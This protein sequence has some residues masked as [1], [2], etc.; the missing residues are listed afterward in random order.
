MRAMVIRDAGA[1][2]ELT[3][4]V[5]PAAG[6]GQVVVRV[7]AC[8][9]CYRDLLDREGKYPFMKRPVVTGHELGGEVIAVGDGVELKPG[10]RVVTTHRPSCGSCDA[11][12][13]GQE[14]YCMQSLA[15]Y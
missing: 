7:A 9:V 4:L 13:R 1:P 15:S 12:R 8:G 14:S 3:E 5:P 11:C 6:A 10:D 2:L